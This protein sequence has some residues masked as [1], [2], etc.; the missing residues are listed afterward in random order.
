MS[1]DG[2]DRDAAAVGNADDSDAA[3]NSDDEVDGRDGDA[4]PDVEP[5]VE[6]DDTEDTRKRWAAMLSKRASSNA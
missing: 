2:N 3:G 4:N 1:G 6:P 5:V